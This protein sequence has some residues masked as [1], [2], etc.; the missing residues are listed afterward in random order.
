MNDLFSQMLARAGLP[1]IRLH[2]ARHTFATWM[3]QSG[4]SLSNSRKGPKPCHEQ[5]FPMALS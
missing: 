3:L 5:E 1:H 2:D 4:V